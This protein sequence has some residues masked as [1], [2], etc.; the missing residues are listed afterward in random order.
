MASVSKK[1]KT[2]KKNHPGRDGRWLKAQGK[3]K[4]VAFY[5]KPDR[6][7]LEADKEG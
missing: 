6:R 5:G 1:A 2:G 4:G 3:L 7:R